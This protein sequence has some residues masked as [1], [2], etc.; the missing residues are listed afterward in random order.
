MENRT[1]FPS[2]D[3]I[4]VLWKSRAYLAELFEGLKRVEYP[5]DRLTV[6]IVDNMSPDDSLSYVWQRIAQSSSEYPSIVIHEP[7]NNL[8]FAGGNNLVMKKSEADYCYLL[9]HDAAFEEGTLREIVEVAEREKRAG[10]LQS[11]IVLMQDPG[12]INSTGNAI[13]FA[14]FGYCND[15]EMPVSEA[16]TEIQNIGYASGAG[17]LYRM[18]ALREVGYFDETLFAY[19]E[20][21]DLGWRL[22]LAGYDN[23]LAPKS[24]LRHRYEFS[25]SIEKWYWMERNRWIVYLVNYHWATILLTLP[26]MIGI[27]IA[28]WIFSFI[29]GWAGKKWKATVWF[30][31]SS[32]LRTLLENRKRV[33]ALRKRKDRE[34]ISTFVAT[35]SHQESTSAFI[36]KVANP[37]L[38][39][40]FSILK[41]LVVW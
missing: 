20:D 10:S 15:Y 38:R 11:L 4:V 5:R 31:K 24:V 35:I 16:P 2:V 19:H 17:V 26:A 22:M 34:I 13:Q 36:E 32:S 3:V 12:K 18:S 23:I 37:I 28:T 25:R 41:I 30:L 29:G 9:N 1:D 8:G 14:G 7:G 27:E 6:H 33:Q 21:L 39:M 40:Y